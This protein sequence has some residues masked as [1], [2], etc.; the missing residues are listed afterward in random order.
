M[1][2]QVCW[3]TREL[4][5]A[6]LET[7]HSEIIGLLWDVIGGVLEPPRKQRDYIGL[8]LRL[9]CGS[10]DTFSPLKRPPELE[11]NSKKLIFEP[12]RAH[13]ERQ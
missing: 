8:L 7:P 6:A 9:F 2:L 12:L 4:L 1:V 3:V 5:L 10:P 13:F 11:D